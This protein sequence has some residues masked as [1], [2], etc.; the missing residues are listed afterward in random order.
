MKFSDLGDRSFETFICT[1]SF[2]DFMRFANILTPGEINVGH[3]STDLLNITEVMLG[4]PC[5]L[6]WSLKQQQTIT[7][8]M[9]DQERSDFYAAFTLSLCT[10]E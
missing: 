2:V 8:K 9:A 4:P 6:T 10:L 1:I 5:K 3:L 7:L